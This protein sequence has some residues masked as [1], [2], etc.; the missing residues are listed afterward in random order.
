MA[1]ELT[2]NASIA[3][4][5]A[6]G[7]SVESEV[8]ALSVTVGTANLPIF[9]ARQNVGTADEALIL[10]DIAGANLGWCFI[11]NVEAFGAN[12][13]Q[14]K[15]ATGGVYFAKLFGGHFAFFSFGSDITAPFVKATG[16][17]QNIEISLFAV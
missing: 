7:V 3:Y 11:K 2:L 14:L 8:A 4:A 6:V 1:S 16:A 5:D 13:V 9:K 15:T 12:Y 17:A 10:G